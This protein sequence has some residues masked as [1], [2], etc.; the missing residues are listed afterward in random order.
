MSLRSPPHQ[1]QVSASTR[2]KSSA[3]VALFGTVSFQWRRRR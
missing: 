2:F 3:H 1:G